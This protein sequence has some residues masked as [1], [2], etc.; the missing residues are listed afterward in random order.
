MT[1]KKNSLSLTNAFKA[2]SSAT[3]K[4]LPHIAH[5]GAYNRH[6][7]GSNQLKRIHARTTTGP[8][9]DHPFDCINF[10]SPVAEMDAMAHVIAYWEHRDDEFSRDVWDKRNLG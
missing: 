5:I 8:I 1:D 3:E 10:T 2:S 7:M 9:E 4:P 6:N